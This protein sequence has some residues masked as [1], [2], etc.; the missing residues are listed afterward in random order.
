MSGGILL[1]GVKEAD[2]LREAMQRARARPVPMR[3]ILR[4][5]A[6]IDQGTDCLTLAERNAAKPYRPGVQM[7][8]LPVGYRVNISF[9]EQPAGMC[10]HLSMSTSAK[11]KVPG[12][13]AVGM[14]LGTLGLGDLT[15]DR[16]W[17][18]E[19]EIDGKPGG[20]A[21]NALVVTEP[22]QAGPPS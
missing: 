5:A 12:P 22:A 17:L 2:A 16:I 4:V 13:E 18:E 10:L 19:F 3:E 6:V 9:E 1:I 11:G 20:Q 7:V 14:V 8:E 21:V 15:P